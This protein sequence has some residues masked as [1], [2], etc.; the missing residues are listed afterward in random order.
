MDN[1]NQI[2]LPTNDKNDPIESD[3][4]TPKHTKDRRH[5]LRATCSLSISFSKKNPRDLPTSLAL[6]SCAMRRRRCSRVSFGS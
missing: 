4:V 6:A 5:V 2:K 3:V 1:N